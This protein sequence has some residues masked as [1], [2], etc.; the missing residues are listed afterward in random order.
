MLSHA[1][2]ERDAESYLV[3]PEDWSHEIAAE[4]ATEENIDLTAAHWPIIDFVREYWDE[5][6]IIP[7]VRHV[8]SH[9]AQEQGIDKKAAKQQVFSLFPYG[10]VKQ[11]CKIAGMQRPRGWS[12]G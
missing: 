11:T 2:L 10:Y 6:K 8:V 1:A 3:N 5:H 9:M 4:L 12:T 7:D